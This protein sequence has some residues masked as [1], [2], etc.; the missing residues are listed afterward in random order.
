VSLARSWGNP[1]PYRPAPKP[2]KELRGVYQLKRP[3]SLAEVN[4]FQQTPYT[5]RICSRCRKQLFYHW[6]L[7][8]LDPIKCSRLYCSRD[9]LGYFTKERYK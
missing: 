5:R 4:H 2:I 1:R 3:K 6:Y 8:F 9:G 7:V